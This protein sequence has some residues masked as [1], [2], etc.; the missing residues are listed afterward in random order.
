MGIPKESN[1]RGGTQHGCK[2]KGCKEEKEALK[3]SGAKSP[4]LQGKIV[5]TGVRFEHPFYLGG[6]RLAVDAG[7]GAT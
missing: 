2:E 7:R 6:L 1:S 4:R 3:L 5:E